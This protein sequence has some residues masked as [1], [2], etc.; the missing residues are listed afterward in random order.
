MSLITNKQTI[1]FPD[2]IFHLICQYCDRY[3]VRVKHQK[4][5]LIIERIGMTRRVMTPHWTGPF[6]EEFLAWWES[7]TIPY[8]VPSWNT[9]SCIS[10]LDPDSC[11]S[12][13][14]KEYNKFVI[15]TGDPDLLLW[16]P[17]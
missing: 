5:C 3:Q 10:P 4:I 14:S 13:P 15:E 11:L 8:Q 1:Y 9:H 2:E 7:I 16:E 6:E 17:D 12:L